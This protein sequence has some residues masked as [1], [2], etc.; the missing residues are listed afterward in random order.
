M[1]LRD[2]LEL[3]CN[4]KEKGLKSVLSITL[5]TR[6][7]DITHKLGAIDLQYSENTDDVDLFGWAS[8]V[9][10]KRDALA[11]DVKEGEDTIQRAEDTIKSLEKQ[12]QDLI[13]AKEEHETQLLSKFTALLNEK[14]LRIRTQQ[15]QIAE[16][17]EPVM[18]DHPKKDVKNPRKRKTSGKQTTTSTESDESDAFEP[19]DAEPPADVGTDVEPYQTTSDESEKG[20]AAQTVVEQELKPGGLAR[21][22]RGSIATPPPRDLPFANQTNPSRTPPR[23]DKSDTVM[24][25]DEETASEDDDEL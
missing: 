22:R 6:V 3:V 15:R 25:D 23:Q 18:N 2:N 17:D 16:Q 8:Q 10:E 9:V 24:G 5:R 14:K 7:E 4:V 12:L 19:M 11:N 20:E 13:V 1:S 21:A